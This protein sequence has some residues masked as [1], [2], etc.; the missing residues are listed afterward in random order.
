MAYTYAP[1]MASQKNATGTEKEWKW[2]GYY[3]LW[4]IRT[5]SESKCFSISFIQGASPE[6]F[7][8][9]GSEPL[10]L[11]FNKQT[12]NA[13]GGDQ[14]RHYILCDCLYLFIS[15]I[16]LK[17]SEHFGRCGKEGSGDPPPPEKNLSK[18]DS[19][20]RKNTAFDT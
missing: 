17:V 19:F 12:K 15:S 20:S 9:M 13:R 4:I 10:T 11:K 2:C 18:T 3:L 7:S 16:F 6:L 8:M 5:R 14:T 1:E